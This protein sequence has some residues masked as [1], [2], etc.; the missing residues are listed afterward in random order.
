MCRAR[1]T[2]GLG[3]QERAL[4][5]EDW[6]RGRLA[7]ARVVGIRR[8]RGIATKRDARPV[9]EERVARCQRFLLRPSGWSSR[10]AVLIVT[11]MMAR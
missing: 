4:V 8:R 6:D 7:A 5:V 9:V 1:L 2:R 10:R 3:E 11:S